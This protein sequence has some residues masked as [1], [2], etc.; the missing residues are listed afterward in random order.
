V[1]TR[2]TRHAARESSPR[3]TPPVDR[4]HPNEFRTFLA[5]MRGKPARGRQAAEPKEPAPGTIR[6]AAGRDPLAQCGTSGVNT[7]AQAAVLSLSVFSELLPY[8]SSLNT[9]SSFG[10]RARRCDPRA[11]LDVAS[12]ALPTIASVTAALALW[13]AVLATATAIAQLVSFW[14]DR[15]RLHVELSCSVLW[16]QP[17]KVIVTVSNRGRQATTIKKAA[18]VAAAGD[19]RIGEGRYAAPVRPE[20]DLLHGAIALVEP[21]N[22]ARFG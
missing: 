12:S 18:L 19:W 1:E 2:P 11:E 10:F 15:P 20:I 14:R 13:G 16:N 9:S 22:I 7:L 6:R 8:G 17:S 5:E 21:G 4:E 3:C